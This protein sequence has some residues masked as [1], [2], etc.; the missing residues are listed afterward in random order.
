MSHNL[1]LENIR[2]FSNGTET[3]NCHP[4]PP[5]QHYYRHHHRLHY[6]STTITGVDAVTERLDFNECMAR[7]VVVVMLF[8]LLLR[9]SWRRW[10]WWWQIEG[11]GETQPDRGEISTK[12]GGRGGSQR[13]RLKLEEED[14][15]GMR[16][17]F[18][19][20]EA[21]AS[22]QVQ[23]LGLKQPRLLTITLSITLA[24]KQP[25]GNQLL[26]SLVS[27]YTLI[28][29]STNTRYSF[30]HYIPTIAVYSFGWANF[31]VCMLRK[32]RSS[33]NA[34]LVCVVLVVIYVRSH[35]LTRNHLA[36]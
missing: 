5:P 19:N 3:W 15:Q 10:W 14:D 34:K 13:D 36:D 28:Q 21:R 1:Y 35:N 4:H 23:K 18:E 30:T 31:C 6:H 22:N 29:I 25:K 12:T 17:W 20:E 26:L 9:S 33:E 8:L 27:Y 32:K 11:W 24:A 16:W 7:V 2:C